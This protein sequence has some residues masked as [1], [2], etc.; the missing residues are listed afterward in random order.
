[1][2]NY[3]F[4]MNC[5]FGLVVFTIG[6]PVEFY[7]LKSYLNDEHGYPCILH[8]MTDSETYRWTDRVI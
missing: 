5:T 2:Q 8:R 6:R 4:R 7:H 1:M 3:R